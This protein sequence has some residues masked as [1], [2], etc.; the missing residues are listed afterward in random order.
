MHR[1]KRRIQ[2]DPQ[3]KASSG[4]LGTYPP[5]ITSHS[6]V[7]IN[8]SPARVENH[9]L[10]ST[11]R[12][13]G[14]SSNRQ[15]PDFSL[16]V[17]YGPSLSCRLHSIMLGLTSNQLRSQGGQAPGDTAPRQLSPAGHLCTESALSTGQTWHSGRSSA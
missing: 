4:S 1:K 14:L 15:E 16:L 8:P 3:F 11:K 12:P 5:Q 2:D 13:S 17:L 6:S 9:W 10:P 7:R